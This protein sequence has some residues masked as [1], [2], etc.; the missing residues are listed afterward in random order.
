MES[1]GQV[2]SPAES[3]PHCTAG[4]SAG[5]P[6]VRVALGTGSFCSQ[7]NTVQTVCPFTIQV[8]G[9]GESRHTC[10]LH[11]SNIPLIIRDVLFLFTPIFSI[12]L[13]LIKE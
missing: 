13:H 10:S 9:T 6:Q 11:V 3:W 2:F 12:N 1:D 8:T 7:T 4:L 5:C